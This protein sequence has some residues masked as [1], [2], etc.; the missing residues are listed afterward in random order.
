M[1]DGAVPPSAVPAGVRAVTFDF[2]NTLI[3]EDANP[4]QWKSA[5]LE[6]ILADHD[7]TTTA[8]QREAALK[9]ASRYY[10]ESWASGDVFDA[11]DWATIF[12]RELGIGDNGVIVDEM[13][14]AVSRGL[15]AEKR[16]AADGIAGA[17]EALTTAGLRVGII[18]DV[19]LTPSVKLR[20]Y[21]D[22]FGLLRHFNHWSFSDEVGAYKPSAVIFEHA[23][24]GL[25]VTP[26]ELVHI[27][28]LRR[29]DV[30]GGRDFGAFTVRYAQFRDDPNGPE[31]HA[32]IRSHREL[33]ALL[34]IS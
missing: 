8:A 21:L 7:V 22:H 20:H 9:V 28:D 25:G 29:T 1:T 2:W 11:N 18:C 33:P 31:A 17:L 23:A 12:A 19:G 16:T 10:D 3:A 6:A 26:A 15:P 30:Q 27:G 24:E 13:A 32:V 34:G 5:A 14:D 4:W